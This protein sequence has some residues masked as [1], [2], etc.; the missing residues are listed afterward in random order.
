MEAN[1]TGSYNTAVGYNSLQS[2][3][4]GHGNTAVGISML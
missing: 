1:T 2:N 4:T 3:T